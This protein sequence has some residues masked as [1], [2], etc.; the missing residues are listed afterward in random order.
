MQEEETFISL[1]LE[2]RVRPRKVYLWANTAGGLL[3][4]ALGYPF[5]LMLVSDLLGRKSLDALLMGGF[6]LVWLYESW[7]P[8]EAYVDWVAEILDWSWLL[9]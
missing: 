2:T 4:Y 8:Y 5:F 3:L 1:D 9:L 6:P 7:G